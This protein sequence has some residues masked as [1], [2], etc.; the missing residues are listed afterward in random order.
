MKRILFS[1]MILVSAFAASGDNYFT[2]GENDTLRV[3]RSQLGENFTF[4]VHAH[5]DGRLNYWRVSFG[6]P[7]GIEYTSMARGSDMDLRYLKLSGDSATYSA[8]LLKNTLD[9]ELSAA[10]TTDV[11][12]YWDYNGDGVLEPYGL[13]KWEAGDYSR[14]FLMTFALSPD[15]TGGEITLDGNVSSS[16]DTRGGTVPD[17][18][19]VTFHRTVTVVVNGLAGDVDGDG[20]VG[21]DDLTALINY[22]VFDD[23]T[24]INMANADA[25]ANGTVGMDDL[26]ALINYLVFNQWP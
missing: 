6:L 15:F 21:M 10:S 12:G 19:P 23:A 20:T 1:L 18:P 26:T 8:L 4:P 2:M 7:P 14:M 5:F 11:Y 3:E 22:L 24:G 25:D 17:Y 9:G 13:V 16:Y